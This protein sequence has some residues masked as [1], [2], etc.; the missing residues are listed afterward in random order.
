MTYLKIHKIKSNYNIQAYIKDE[1][2]SSGAKDFYCY[3][4]SLP[5]NWQGH[6]KDLPIYYSKNEES[7]EDF[8]KD[9]E[10]TGYL[11]KILSCSD[12]TTGLCSNKLLV[13]A[14]HTNDRVLNNRLCPKQI[15]PLPYGNQNSSAQINVL[16]Y[17]DP[18]LKKL[19][20]PDQIKQLQ[21]SVNNLNHC[22]K[23][24]LGIEIQ[25]HIT[26]KNRLT[27]C[28]Q[29]FSKKVNDIRIVVGRGGWRR[30]AGMLVEEA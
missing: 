11:K 24:K 8:V 1:R 12:N 17:T 20:T 6:I 18:L 19:L 10:I 3:L 2:L 21:N 23:E 14:I 29:E 16:S 28:G 26:K 30:A 13:L 25:Y 5:N 27:G 22:D 7:I 9:L 15:T 4:D